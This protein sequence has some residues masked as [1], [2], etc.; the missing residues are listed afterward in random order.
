M[1]MTCCKG[2]GEENYTKHERTGLFSF[3]NCQRVLVVTTGIR[4]AAGA[5]PFAGRAA[6]NAMLSS[7]LLRTGGRES[8]V[9]FSGENRRARDG[10]RDFTAAASRTINGFCANKT[11]IKR[12]Q[13]FLVAVLR[14][15]VRPYYDLQSGL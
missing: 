7:S 5:L 4:D 13:I 2:D 6:T 15:S 12:V 1:D 8:F 3:P 11:V 14:I 9:F 10:L